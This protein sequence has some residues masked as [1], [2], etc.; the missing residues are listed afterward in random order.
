MIDCNDTID[1]RFARM[2]CDGCGATFEHTLIPAKLG[3]I[4]AQLCGHAVAAGWRVDETATDRDACPACAVKR[5][6]R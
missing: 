4:V 5:G 3:G 2:H 6:A 1:G